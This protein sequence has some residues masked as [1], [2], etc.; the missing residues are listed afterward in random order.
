MCG[1]QSNPLRECNEEQRERNQRNLR[2][3]L[4]PSLNNDQ[5][6][7]RLAVDGYD[8]E[9]GLSARLLVFYV[10]NRKAAVISS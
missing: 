1:N 9:S 3:R 2:G 7:E 6:I 10:R 5:D 4:R 8:G